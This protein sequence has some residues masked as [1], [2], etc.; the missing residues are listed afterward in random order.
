MS[1]FSFYQMYY[2]VYSIFG[3]LLTVAS[4]VTQSTLKRGASLAFGGFQTHIVIPMKQ[5]SELLPLG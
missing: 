2:P 3:F 1:P 4:N 5:I